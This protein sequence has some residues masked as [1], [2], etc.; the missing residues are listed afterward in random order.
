MS[1]KDIRELETKVEQGDEEARFAL[2]RA[3]RRANLPIER[4]WESLPISLGADLKKPPAAIREQLLDDLTNLRAAEVA[5]LAVRY[6]LTGSTPITVYEPEGKPAH[7][8]VLARKNK[9][10]KSWVFRLRKTRPTEGDVSQVFQNKGRWHHAHAYVEHPIPGG[11]YAHKLIDAAKDL[12]EA[13]DVPLGKLN[14]TLKG[15]KEEWPDRAFYLYYTWTAAPL[16]LEVEEW[17]GSYEE[18]DMEPRGSHYK[19]DLTGLP[20][21][22]SLLFPQKNNYSYRSSSQF[23]K[24]I[25]DGPAENAQRVLAAFVKAAQ[26]TQ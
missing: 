1:D 11:I 6:D 25:Y 15:P 14:H 16:R 21:G 22:A 3:L 5:A 8:L 2:Q 12:F 17:H 7:H 23:R 18:M 9:R 10:T 19:A 26:A 20:E 4:A 24:V 13:L